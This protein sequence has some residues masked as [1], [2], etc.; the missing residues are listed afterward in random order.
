MERV[1][2]QNKKNKY[3]FAEKM[4]ALFDIS[5][6]NALELYNK[7]RQ[8]IFNQQQKKYP[9]LWMASTTT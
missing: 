5:H 7:L 8:T 6:A 1:N 9:S 2:M 4:D 3:I